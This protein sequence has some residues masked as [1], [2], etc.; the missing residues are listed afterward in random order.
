MSGV[1]GELRNFPRSD[2][3][4]VFLG[5]FFLGRHD[6]FCGVPFD[7]SLLISRINFRYRSDHRDLFRE[8][9]RHFQ[10]CGRG[11]TGV[12][13]EISHFAC[14]GDFYFSVAGERFLYVSI[15]AK[16]LDTPATGAGIVVPNLALS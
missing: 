9:G 2:L 13:C 4:L 7:T 8:S 14:C 6:V 10:R 1:L 5:V 3:R 16:V 12:G 15:D 11:T